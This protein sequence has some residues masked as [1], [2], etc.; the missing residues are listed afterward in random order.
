MKKYI[1]D[2]FGSLPIGLKVRLTREQAEAR[3]HLLPD[4]AVKKL[5]ETKAK[6]VTLVTAQRLSFKRGEEVG[7]EGDLDRGLEIMFGLEP[8]R[9]TTP[10]GAVSRGDEGGDDPD[11]TPPQLDPADPE[12]PDDGEGEQ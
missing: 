3:L 7:I 10:N 11:Q 5:A 6:S 4:D 2:Q 12:T 9:K 8:D 1:V